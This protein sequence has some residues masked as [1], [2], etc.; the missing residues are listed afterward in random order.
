MTMTTH[1][2]RQH[3]L[4]RAIAID[5]AEAAGEVGHVEAVGFWV[6]SYAQRNAQHVQNVA[7]DRTRIAGPAMNRGDSKPKRRQRSSRG[8]EADTPTTTELSL[9]EPSTNG[10]EASSD[11]G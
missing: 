4:A 8:S 2:E 5:Q 11:V 9:D 7:E 1:I 6:D 10:E 3:D